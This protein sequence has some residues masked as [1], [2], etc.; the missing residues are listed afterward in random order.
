MLVHAVE[1]L[2]CM[3]LCLHVCAYGEL[4]LKRFYSHLWRGICNQLMTLKKCR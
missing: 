4:Y 3:V 1:V 2:V